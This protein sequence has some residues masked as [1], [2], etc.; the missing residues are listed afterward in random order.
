MGETHLIFKISLFFI[1]AACFIIIL[2]LMRSSLKHAAKKQKKIE[3]E[4]QQNLNSLFIFIQHQYVI[5]FHRCLLLI[6]PLIFFILWKNILFSG[7]LFLG[8]YFAPQFILK[9]LSNKRRL[10]FETGLPDSLSQ[11]A[12]SMKS[13][14]S[15]IN[16]VDIMAQETPGPIGEEFSLLIKEYRMGKSIE[17][18]LNA[19]SERIKSENFNLALAATLVALD[20]GGNLSE[21]Y[22]RLSDALRQKIKLDQKIKSFTS[23]G[24]LQGI[25]VGLLPFGMIFVL[26]IIEPEH[27]KLLF[28]SWMGLFTL[29]LIIVLEFL[30]LHFIKKIVSI[31]V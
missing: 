7:V 29:I 8:V 31:E 16:A 5:Y 25:V 14:N 1:G 11:I 21:T 23:Q 2:L 28:H 4:W 17:D 27:M 30:G 15:F 3:N 26:H 22:E 13:G 10:A 19:L 20:V 18:A 9:Y 24:K 12:G 6:A